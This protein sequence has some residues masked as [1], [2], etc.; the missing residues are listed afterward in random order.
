MSLKSNSVSQT[1]RTGFNA[2]W[3][4]R[5]AGARAIRQALVESLEDRRLL[6]SAGRLLE[7]DFNTPSAWPLI[8]ASATGGITT[9]AAQ[10]A[11]GTVDIEGGTTKTG[12]AALGVGAVP[13]GY[14]TADLSSGRLA[15]SNTETNLGKLTLSFN[16]SASQARPVTVRVESYNAQGVRTGGLEGSVLPAAADT[17]QRFALD[18]SSMKPT[19]GGTFN[20]TAPGISFGFEVGS[21]SGWT[22]SGTREVRVDN[23]N[24]SKP[25]YYVSPN[26]NNSNSGRSESLAFRTPQKALDVSQPGD[27]IVFMEGNTG[28][29][30]DYTSINFYSMNFSKGGTPSA[31]VSVKN[32]PGHAPTFYNEYWDAIKVGTGSATADSTVPAIAYI[33][34]RGLHVRGNADTVNVTNPELLGAV[35]PKTNNNGISVDGRYNTNRPHHIRVADNLIEYCSGGGTGAGEAD[36]VQIENNVIRNTSWWT[37]YATSGISVLSAYNFDGTVGGYTRLVLNNV[38][39]GNQTFVKWAQINDF[40]DGNGIIIDVN[41]DTDDTPGGVTQGRTLVQNNVVFNNGGSGI[42]TYKADHVDIFNNTAYMNSASV[43]LEYGQIFANQSLDNRI[44]NNI[45]VAP[46]AGAGQP[47]EPINGGTVPNGTNQIIYRNNLYWGGNTAPRM[48]VEDRI[49]NPIFI[50]PSIDPAVADFRLQPSSPAINSATSE[51]PFLDLLANIRNGLPDIGAYE[52]YAGVPTIVAAAAVSPGLV[53]G[54]SAIAFVSAGDND[55]AAGLSYNWS[56]TT[57]PAGASDPVFSVNAAAN[58]ATT[59]VT[60]DKAGTYL[61]LVTVTD[62]QANFSTSAVTLTVQQTLTSGLVVSPLAAVVNTGSSLQFTSAGVDQFGDAVL[63]P[64]VVWSVTGAGNSISAGGLLTAGNTPGLYTVTASSGA[65][66]AQSQVEVMS[67]QAPVTL[68]AATSRKQH[69]AAGNYD[70]SLSIAG[71]PSAEPRLGGAT[72]LVLTFSQP[73]QASDGVLGANEFQIVGATFVSATFSGNRVIL[74]V[75]DTSQQQV[76]TPLGLAGLDGAPLASNT[77]LTV[78]N[79]YKDANRDGVISPADVQLIRSQRRRPLSLTN[80][81]CDSNLSGTITLED[82]PVVGMPLVGGPVRAETVSAAFGINRVG[83]NDIL[84]N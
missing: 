16:L 62:G 35:N 84:W 20:P 79:L 33:E 69:A 52:Y 8:S 30:Y 1:S 65:L 80:Y 9:T 71:S 78:T 34:I 19:G 27:I 74:H 54:T 72:T 82:E 67:G 2:R 11:V 55:G 22:G 49:L 83:Y 23:V 63:S 53:I 10:G 7:F 32:Y 60:F 43:E 76:I 47:S 70:L 44:F 58:A 68:T 75:S 45:L 4:A 66:S 57:K 56:T 46:V 13:S 17:H 41:K 64:S 3:P 5:V 61:L 39:S 31:W 12:A 37:R 18:L 24:Y 77:S 15:V 14:W 40:S 21:K 26:G 29:A 28:Q 51:S 48:G 6:A 36:W 81:F 38:V 50:S 25:A 42:H 59:E 73:L